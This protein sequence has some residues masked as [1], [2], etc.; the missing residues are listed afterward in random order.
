MR[1]PQKRIRKA[2]KRGIKDEK[3]VDG[4][5]YTVANEAIDA[6]SDKR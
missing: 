2:K 4:S 6:W 1:K 5:P 3:E